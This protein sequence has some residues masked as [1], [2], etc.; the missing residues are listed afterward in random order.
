MSP[1]I[2]GS[3]HKQLVFHIE[4]NPVKA[5][6]VERAENWRF[7]SVRERQHLAGTGCWKAMR[8]ENGDP[9]RE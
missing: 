1:K 5:K 8:V 9:E 4:H 7:S 2:C 6:L 3:L